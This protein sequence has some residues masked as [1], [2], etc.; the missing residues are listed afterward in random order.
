M[1]IEFGVELLKKTV[2]TLP[3]IFFFK[4]KVLSSFYHEILEFVKYI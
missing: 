4:K 1:G 2:V 3:V